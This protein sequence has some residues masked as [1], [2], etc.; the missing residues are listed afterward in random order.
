MSD[1]IYNFQIDLT[2]ETDELTLEDNYFKLEDLGKELYICCKHQN[3]AV[4]TREE[5]ISLIPKLQNWV[6]FKLNEEK[7][8]SKKSD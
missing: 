7:S 3:S 2:F 1:T 8:V 5:V 6:N 4:L